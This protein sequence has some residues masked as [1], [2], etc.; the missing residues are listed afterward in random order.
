M[1]AVRQ[2]P[3]RGRPPKLSRRQIV[4]AAVQCIERGH[5]DALTIRAVATE[6]GASPMS[7][8]RHVADRDELVAL[9]VDEILGG[10]ELPPHPRR[11]AE[12]GPWFTA[13]AHEVRRV[14]IRYPG[15]AEHLLVMGPSGEHGLA[16]MDR[17]CHVLADTGRDAEEVGSAYMWLMVTV[18]AYAARHTRTADFAGA[19]GLERPALRDLFVERVA[20]FADR[21]THLAAVAPLMSTD[22]ERSFAD[23]VEH[24]VRVLTA[25]VRMR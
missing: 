4:D 2:A 18:A 24:V 25:P 21:F 1:V 15:V 22:A 6:V 5:L 14:L 8:Y 20:P 23:A 7:L 12:R 17:I 9:A 19:A 16:V 10:V 11:V 13:M 3:S